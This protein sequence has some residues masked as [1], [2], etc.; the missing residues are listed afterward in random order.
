MNI[1]VQI[2]APLCVLPS[3]QAGGEMWMV[4]SVL[5]SCKPL[6]LEGHRLA[7]SLARA[8]AS[9]PARG[10][11]LGSGESMAGESRWWHLGR[12]ALLGLGCCWAGFTSPG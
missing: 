12:N 2:N 10:G 5:E 7:C 9:R 8:P 11:S 6:L 3:I 4:C 1:N